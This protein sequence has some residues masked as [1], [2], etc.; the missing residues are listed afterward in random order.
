MD[1]DYLNK[2]LRITNKTPH[3]LGNETCH[4]FSI[5]I[6]LIKVNEHT[7][8][9][10]ET[11]SY[12]LRR[13]PGEICFP[14]GRIDQNEKSDTAAIRETCEELRLKNDEITL[15]GPLDFLV[16]PYEM[17]IYP[18]V[19]WINKELTEISPNP[20][21]VDQIFSVPLSD[22]ITSEPE[23]YNINFTATPADNFPFHLIPGG[24]NYNWRVRSQ[25]EYFYFYKDK[26]IWGLTARILNDFL[27]NLK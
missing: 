15:V 13:Q 1:K 8:I 11:R 9:L 12:Q 22:L 23:I 19:G 7:H 3:V 10:F 27:E 4:S 17:I 20:A 2:L 5:F 26:V 24:K 18:Y 14:G 21:E 16:K 25:K 6:P